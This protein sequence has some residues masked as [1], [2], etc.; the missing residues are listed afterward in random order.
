MVLVPG[1]NSGA[2]VCRNEWWQRIR[3]N[4]ELAREFIRSGFRLLEHESHEVDRYGNPKVFLNS[5]IGTVE[6]GMLVRVWGIQRD[7]TEK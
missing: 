7:I 1:T 2:G 6:S 4:I 3:C 5:M